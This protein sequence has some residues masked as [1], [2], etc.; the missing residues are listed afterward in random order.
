MGGD[1]VSVGGYELL[2]ADCS[3]EPCLG[4]D[5]HLVLNV[6]LIVRKERTQR[7]SQVV[8]KLPSFAGYL[9]NSSI[10]IATN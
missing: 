2:G 4:S 6:Q 5:R 3:S 10:G 9:V 7:S 8:T 1:D